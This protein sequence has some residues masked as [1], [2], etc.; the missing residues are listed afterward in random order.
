M[1]LFGLLR[2]PDSA[3]SASPVNGRR[4][5]PMA[6]P[7][8]NPALW[9]RGVSFGLGA[10]L[11]LYAGSR[12]VVDVTRPSFHTADFFANGTRPPIED[13]G[14]L[15]ATLSFDG[16]VLADRATV[17]AR[18]AI[19]LPLSQA[20]RQGANAQAQA[21]A[22]SA[23]AVSPINSAMW[24]LLGFLK[25]AAG[26]PT[27][28]PLKMS[29]LTGPLPPDAMANRIRAVATSPA[30]GDE[31]I[32]VLGQLDVRSLLIRNQ[33]YQSSLAASYRQ[34]TADGKTFLL[35]AT[36]LV[37]AKFSNQLRQSR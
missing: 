14:A 23:L 26:D 17:K 16:D 24:L 9:L 20:A 10:V 11:A 21:A 19:E 2:R 34:A 7:N 4:S 29:F 5:N 15:A 32:R 37:D 22:K 31:E 25:A 12:I 33:D 18:Q 6:R 3:A 28:G 30:A 27:T 8:P 36:N 13:T 35:D 1:N